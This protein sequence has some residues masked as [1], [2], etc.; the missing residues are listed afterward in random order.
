MTSR[1]NSFLV[2]SLQLAVNWNRCIL[3]QINACSC[4][5]KNRPL[6]AW[7]SH[8]VWCS[9]KISSTRSSDNLYTQVAHS[10]LYARNKHFA[11]CARCVLDVRECIVLLYWNGKNAHQL[12]LVAYQLRL[13]AHRDVK[14][15]TDRRLLTS[16]V[17]H[18]IWATFFIHVARRAKYTTFKRLA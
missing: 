3:F 15:V 9:N 10:K 8:M 18:T 5:H 1:N 4:T 12:R 16:C 14:A 2:P 13:V 6:V 17:R 7:I 11:W